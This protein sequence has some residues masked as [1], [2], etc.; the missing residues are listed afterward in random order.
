MSIGMKLDQYNWTD[1]RT[2]LDADGF[3]VLPQVLDAQ[4]RHSITEY[5]FHK[6]VADEHLTQTFTKPQAERM[7]LPK[8]RQATLEDEALGSGDIFYF[9]AQL[10]APLTLLREEFYRRLVTIANRWQDVLGVKSSFPKEYEAFKRSNILAGQTQEQ[11]HITEL[12]VENYILLHQKNQGENVFPFQLAAV[13]SQSEDD[14]S[15]GDFVMVEQRPRMQSRPAVVK[16]KPGD[17]L[18][19]STSA[20]PFKGNKGYYRVTLK[21]AVSRVRRGSRVGLELLFHQSAEPMAPLRLP[22]F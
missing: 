20:R 9:D 12:R 11:S 5:F 10:P 13:L 7:F 1:I 15:G 6:S 4:F 17:V 18:I 8:V 16:L 19:L 2:Q 21:H 3:A 22:N 14:F